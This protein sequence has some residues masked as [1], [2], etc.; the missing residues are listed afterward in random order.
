MRAG[1]DHG[2]SGAGPAVLNRR[3]T[4]L[5]PLMRRQ[6][7]LRTT[8]RNAV[9]NASVVGQDLVRRVAVVSRKGSRRVAERAPGAPIPLGADGAFDDEKNNYLKIVISSLAL[10]GYGAYLL[11]PLEGKSSSM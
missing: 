3:F 10:G 1:S 9:T 11:P 4:V 2:G 6:R 5:N 8:E 7:R